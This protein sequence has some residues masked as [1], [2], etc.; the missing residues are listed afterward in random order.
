MIGIGRNN[1]ELKILQV[2]AIEG[3]FEKLLSPLILALIQE[4][5]SVDLACADPRSN[6]FK[7][8]AS[9]AYRIPFERKAVSFSHF[10]A[11]W[12][13]FFL[14]RENDYSIMHVHT[15]IAAAISRIAAKL[16][17][18]EIVVYTAHGF[19]LRDDMHPILKSA[20]I[21]IEKLL[22]RYATDWLFIQ[23]KEDTCLA[24]SQNFL[25]DEA[26]IVRIGNG[27]NI[28]EFVKYTYSGIIRERLGIDNDEFVIGFIG[29]I[30][31]EKGVMELIEA[32]KIVSE[33]AYRTRL[34]VIGETPPSESDDGLNI[35][36]REYIVRNN[37]EEKVT[38]TGFRN[39]IPELINIMDVFVLPSHREG[40][41][42]TII[43]AMAS[44]KPVIATD[45]SGCR[46][47]VIDKSTGLLVPMRD[48]ASLAKAIEQLLND[49]ALAKRM[50]EAG[51]KRAIEEYDEKRVIEKQLRIFRAI[52][53][54][55]TGNS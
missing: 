12:K 4:G 22:G 30:V 24:K 35:E 52:A 27:I 26:R 46:E 32:F 40:L 48:S 34:L 19:Y 49:G 47:E 6:N 17:G 29:R 55:L 37:L 5:F 28:D 8:S 11:L 1:N 41:P 23:G 7:G 50:G 53:M 16:A 45:I 3:T 21:S 54:S 31:R 51:R 10:K 44:G 9:H 18:T 14:L 42:R 15:P 43:E 36:L 20:V 39:D 2:A 25:K 13:L 33:E 38:L